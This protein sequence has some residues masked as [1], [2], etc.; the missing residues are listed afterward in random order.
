VEVRLA[1]CV[2]PS[3][4]AVRLA[5]CVLPSDVHSN[6]DRKVKFEE[7]PNSWELNCKSNAKDHY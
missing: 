2:L 6:L 7:F 5:V 1:V 3:D 4:V